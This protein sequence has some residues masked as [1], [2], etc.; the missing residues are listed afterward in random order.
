MTDIQAKIHSYAPYMTQ[1]RRAL[2]RIPEIGYKEYKTSRFIMEQLQQ[3][4]CFEVSQCGE[5]GIKAVFMSGANAETVAFRA[6][7]DALAIRENT[8]AEY[9]SCHNGFMHACGHDGHM[10]I[11]LGLARLINDCKDSIR[12]N[13]VLLFQPAEESYGGAE[14]MID[15]G[16]LEV[17]AVDRMYGYHLMPS[18]PVGTVGIKS[19]A[20][21]AQASEFDVEFYGKSAHGAMPHC[22]ADAIAAAC[23][24]VSGAQG[25]ISRCVN[26][27][28]QCVVTFGSISGG[29]VRNIVCDYC[30]LQGTMRTFSDEIYSSVRERLTGFAEA[31]ARMF[32]CS[33]VYTER[34]LYPFVNNDE[35]LCNELRDI[36]GPAAVSVEPMMIAE[37]F[38]FYQR[39]VPAAFMFLGCGDGTEEKKLHSDCFDFDERALE[40]G[41]E[42]Y[43]RILELQG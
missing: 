11:L 13:I 14:S 20:L 31:S 42:I 36:A 8:Q 25:I 9:S 38:S 32:G 35:A 16:C 22:G 30:K 7:M 2:H 12:Y 6:D 5:T 21:M 37:D 3:Y 43:S 28:E 23:Q 15:A 18:L 26:P 33:A 10:A 19:G 4:P 40:V 17:P 41:L 1:M 24:F 34:V 29:E 39:R 27:A